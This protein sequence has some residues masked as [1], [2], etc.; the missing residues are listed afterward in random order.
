MAVRPRI[1]PSGSERAS[2]NAEYLTGISVVRWTARSTLAVATAFAILLGV[3]D[4]AGIRSGEEEIL[5][6]ASERTSLPPSFVIFDLVFVILDIVVVVIVI[7]PPG[8]YLCNTFIQL[9]LHTYTSQCRL[10]PVS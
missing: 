3:A 5:L 9:R 1:G 6:G 10:V 2:G 8:I 4:V 7:V